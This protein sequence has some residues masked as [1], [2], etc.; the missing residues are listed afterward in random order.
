[1]DPNDPLG[2]ERAYQA[3]IDGLRAVKKVVL[4]DPPDHSVVDDFPLPGEDQFDFMGRQARSPKWSQQVM[5]TA[6]MAGPIINPKGSQAYI[7]AL[8]NWAGKSKLVNEAG[9]PLTLFHATKGD[10]DTFKPNYNGG[11]WL[12]DDPL[13]IRAAHNAGAGTWWNEGA[14]IMPVHAK[15]ENPLVIKPGSA[16]YKRRSKAGLPTTS[17]VFTPEEKAAAIRAGYDGIITKSANGGVEEYV[18][19]DP[20]QIKSATGNQGTFNPAD[21]NILRALLL[22]GGVAGA[23]AATED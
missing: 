13:K 18:V 14:S 5:N 9:D 6:T 16:A 7:D 21:P 15:L 8:R 10:F 17:V 1:M 23:A 19:F 4:P 20:P 22:G 12:A 3:L 2:T 11:F